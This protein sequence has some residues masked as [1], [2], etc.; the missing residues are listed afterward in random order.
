MSIITKNL[1]YCQIKQYVA[2][3]INVNA[4]MDLS[5]FTDTTTMIKIIHK[6]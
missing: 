6:V 5:M 3:V 4:H 1:T 2:H